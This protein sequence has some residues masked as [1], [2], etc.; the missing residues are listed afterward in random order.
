MRTHG[1]L[2]LR[3]W[4]QKSNQADRREPKARGSS[5]KN[6]QR[7]ESGT[8]RPT[9]ASTGV[10]ERTRKQMW[11]PSNKAIWYWSNFGMA[12][13]FLTRFLLDPFPELGWYDPV[14]IWVSGGNGRIRRRD[15]G[16]ILQPAPSPMML[17][18]YA[19]L[20]SHTNLTAPLVLP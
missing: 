6:G 12:R 16:N 15:Q 13:K 1:S 9:L 14:Q 18:S 20:K 19:S 4:R 10:A 5:F 8:R 2:E 7:S 17:S 11:D 3:V